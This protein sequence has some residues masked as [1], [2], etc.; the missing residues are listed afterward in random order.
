LR[1]TTSR[2][3]CRSRAW[4]TSTRSPPTGGAGAADGHP[5]AA[6]VLAAPPDRAFDVVH[7]LP[8][9]AR[10]NLYRYPR[11]T[12]EDLNRPEL[13][14]C[15]WTALNFFVDPPDDK[16]LTPRGHRR[17]QRDYYLVHNNFQLGDIISVDGKGRIFHVAVSRRRLRLTKNGHL[18]GTMGDP[19]DTLVDYYRVSVEK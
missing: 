13:T 14:N 16:H 10:T 9:F 6:R 5:A 7:L 12:A 3:D 17:L 15:L 4:R 1:Q 18:T 2:L 19:L 11:V 8:A